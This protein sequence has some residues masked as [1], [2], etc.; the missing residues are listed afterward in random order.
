MKNCQP[1][2]TC[3][4]QHP[5]DPMPCN[6]CEDSYEARCVFTSQRLTCVNGDN[7]IEADVNMED[8]IRQLL[9]K[10]N[11]LETKIVYILENCCNGTNICE[12]V[13]IVSV[14]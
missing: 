5:Y 12:S 6:N 4:E 9:C 11:E 14:K 3:D 10:I 1:C 8:V 7:F 13:E 2:N